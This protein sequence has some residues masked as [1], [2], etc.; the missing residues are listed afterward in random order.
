MK[1][2]TIMAVALSV[3]A[4]TACGEGG[5]N[6]EI[7]MTPEL[8][9]RV[10]VDGEAARATAL[11][12]VPGGKVRSGSGGGG[13]KL[14]DS[15]DIEVAGQEGVQEVQVDALDGKVVGAEH[16]TEAREAD[17]ALKEG[18]TAALVEET[19]GL[20]DRAKITDQAARTAALQG[21]PAVASSGRSSRRRTD[22]SSTP[23]ISR[24]RGRRASRSCT[25]TVTG[26]VVSVEHEEE[27]EEGGM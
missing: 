1:Y 3:V 15:F 16:E 20:K 26:K 6:G 24:S 8:A 21:C 22:S 2:L 13:G 7:Q 25:W 11:A 9:A 23:T 18:G 19:P 27:G 12:R 10:K 14:T 5:E 17:E 4:M